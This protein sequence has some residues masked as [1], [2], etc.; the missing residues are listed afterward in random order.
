MPTP[1]DYGAQW[2]EYRVRRWAVVG[3][4]VAIAFVSCFRLDPSRDTPGGQA[5]W[6]VAF[7]ILVTLIVRWRT[8]PCP[9]CGHAFLPTGRIGRHGRNHCN[10]CGLPM[11]SPSDPDADALSPRW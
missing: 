6:W 9:R 11:W 5:F 8:W 1:N 3:C 7:I 10:R 2:R 4:V